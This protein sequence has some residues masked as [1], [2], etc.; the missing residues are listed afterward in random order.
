MLI[1]SVP[2]KLTA[3][4]LHS[5]LTGAA[6]LRFVVAVFGDN[7]CWIMAVPLSEAE[8]EYSVLLGDRYGMFV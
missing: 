3:S 5:R 4:E 8:G 1:A 7:I 6:N 2:I